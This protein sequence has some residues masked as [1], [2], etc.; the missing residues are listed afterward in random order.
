MA[1]IAANQRST[2]ATS[3]SSGQSL[4]IIV[5]LACLAGFI[6]DIAILGLPPDPFNIQWRIK[7]LQQ[8]GDRSIVLLFGLA[9]TMYGV[10]YKRSIRKQLAL[11]CL[12][13]GVMFSVSGILA[14]HDSLKFQDMTLVRIANQENQV[15]SQIESVQDNPTDIPPELTPEILDQ[16]TQELSVRADSIKKNATTGIIKFGASSI[17]NLIVTGCA[18]IALGRFGNR[19][20]G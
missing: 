9:L 20:V 4:C 16:A 18:L 5:G 19:T 13:I 15:R 10:L 11:I 3:T 8:V 2:S 6:V 12:A 7:L 1:N 17:S 14:A